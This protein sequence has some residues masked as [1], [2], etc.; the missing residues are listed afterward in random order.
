LAATVACGGGQ[1]APAT[2][3]AHSPAADAAVTAYLTAV[4]SDQVSVEK[5]KREFFN[6]CFYGYSTGY[7]PTLTL[8]LPP[9]T[10]FGTAVRTVK[11]DLG[12]RAVPPK[13]AAANTE[14]IVDLTNLAA[15]IDSAMTQMKALG[16]NFGGAGCCFI[17][18]ATGNSFLQKEE[19]D[20]RALGLIP[21]STG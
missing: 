4:Q 12:A 6:K 14:L 16:E 1:A 9:M 17:D 18:N 5:G 13:L 21:L 7:T 15:S 20:V 3:A 11:N 2:S 10:A 19:A 8:C